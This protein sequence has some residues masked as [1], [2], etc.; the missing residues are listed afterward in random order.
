MAIQKFAKLILWILL[1]AS[2]NACDLMDYGIYRT[3]HKGSFASFVVLNY[4]NI[5]RDILLEKGDYLDSL[6]SQLH[7]MKLDIDVYRLKRIVYVSQNAYDFSVA[8]TKDS[9]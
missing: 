4:S 3:L 6:M 7:N 1:G 8:I 9:D 2:V 5:K